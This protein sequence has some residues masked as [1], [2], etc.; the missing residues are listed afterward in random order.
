[1]QCGDGHVGKLEYASDVTIR[2]HFARLRNAHS[3]AVL[4][5]TLPAPSQCATGVA[6]APSTVGRHPSATAADFS[7]SRL[8]SSR[9]SVGPT[10]AM[11]GQ[12]HRPGLHRWNVKGPTSVQTRHANAD[13]SPRAKLDGKDAR[14]RRW[15]QLPFEFPMGLKTEGVQLASLK[16]RLQAHSVLT[17]GLRACWQVGH[18]H[19]ARRPG[20]G[21]RLAGRPAKLRQLEAD[22][23]HRKRTRPYKALNIALLDILAGGRVHSGVVR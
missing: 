7:S 5:Q 20:L 9:V 14:L 17:R 16:R 11:R 8:F 22:A 18:T 15:L 23:K 10:H 12:Q 21:R 13:A 2:L 3:V 4:C 19:Q 1:M 6:R